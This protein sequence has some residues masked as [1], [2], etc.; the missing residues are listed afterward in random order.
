MSADI[1]PLFMAEAK[2]FMV[3]CG[4]CGYQMVPNRVVSLVMLSQYADLRPY[5]MVEFVCNNSPFECGTQMA[6]EVDLN[7]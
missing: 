1:R 3:M 7:A 5:A 6:I 4:A 2:K